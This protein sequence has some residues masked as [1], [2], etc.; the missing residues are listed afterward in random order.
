SVINRLNWLEITEANLYA[1]LSACLEIDIIE[2]FAI[3]HTIA[4]HIEGEQRH[5][6]NI[7]FFRVNGCACSWFVYVE[8]Q[9]FEWRV[10][11][12]CNSCHRQ[13][14]EVG[15]RVTGSQLRIPEL[16]KFGEEMR[17]GFIVFFNWPE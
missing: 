9:F 16:Q 3:S 13:V 1:I 4:M 6:Y 10:N 11:I 12:R 17:V 8:M 7:D 5:E 2:T 14:F 15:Y